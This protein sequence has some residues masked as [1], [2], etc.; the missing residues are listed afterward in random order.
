MK[1]LKNYREQNNYYN[2][3][4]KHLLKPKREEDIINILNKMTPF[5]ARLNMIYSDL[6]ENEDITKLI[7]KRIKDSIDEL[8]KIISEH[9][10]EQ[11]SDLVINVSKWVEKNGG[12]HVHITDTGLK[13]LSEHIMEFD[14]K[15]PNFTIYNDETFNIFEKLL[16]NMD[17]CEVKYN[18]IE[19]PDF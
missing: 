7:E 16:R 13:Q 11:L 8:D 14:F 18:N 5:G 10:L 15:D 2:E 17:I 9:T 4:I 3:S 12:N 1:H 6:D 19:S